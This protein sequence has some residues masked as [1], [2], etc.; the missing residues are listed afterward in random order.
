[1]MW[2]PLCF[3]HLHIWIVLIEL[4]FSLKLQRNFKIVFVLFFT[5]FSSYRNV[6]GI[7]F[8][9]V[10]AKTAAKMKIDIIAH[11]LQK[12]CMCIKINDLQYCNQSSKCPRN[13]KERHKVTFNSTSG[14]LKDPEEKTFAVNDIYSNIESGMNSWWYWKKAFIWI[15]MF[16]LLHALFTWFLQSH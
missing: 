16:L 13:Y 2:F 11:N 15:I 12:T 1:M 5:Y 7:S 3:Q 6:R 10:N 9:S 8:I 14:T 4:E